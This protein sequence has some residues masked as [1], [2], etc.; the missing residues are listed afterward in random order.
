MSGPQPL[1]WATLA[2]TALQLPMVIAGH[3]SKTVADLFALM[4][5]TLSLVAGL[6]FS[7]W[8]KPPTPGGAARG[9]FLA[10]G[11]CALIGILVS[12]LLGDVPGFVLA[13]GTASSSVTGA[14]G[15]LIGR[16]LAPG[17]RPA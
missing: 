1:L 17:Q 4:G 12:Y 3:W 11:A 8:A 9:G 6:L 15:A 5:M 13:L 14:L 7:V 2:G 10:G 16:R